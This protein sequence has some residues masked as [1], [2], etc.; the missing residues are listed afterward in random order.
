MKVFVFFV[1]CFTIKQFEVFSENLETMLSFV[2]V[3]NLHNDD[4]FYKKVDISGKENLI[5]YM[6]SITDYREQL[7]DQNLNVFYIYINCKFSNWIIYELYNFVN[8]FPSFY[9]NEF[10]YD[11]IEENVI[12]KD[13]E[14]LK[15][16]LESI[17]IYIEHFITELN[18]FISKK[19][20]FLY[21]SD[22]STLNALL[23]LKLKI[24]FITADLTLSDN[25]IISMIL[26][27]M[28]DIQR[29][30]IIN[31]NDSLPNYE[32]THFYGFSIVKN[33]SETDII[34]FLK[35]IQISGSEF[36]LKREDEICTIN[37]I[38]L[39]TI[40]QSIFD[41]DLQVKVLTTETESIPLIDYFEQ[42]QQSYDIE[43]IF[44]YQKNVLTAI[45]QLLYKLIIMVNM[46]SSS[47]NNIEKKRYNDILDDILKTIADVPM[48]YTN[49]IKK[50]SNLF[51]EAY[52]K[53]DFIENIKIY[54]NSLSSTII[55]DYSRL[56][57]IDVVENKLIKT[58]NALKQNIK[59]IQCFNQYF[60]L[61]HVEHH[62]YYTPFTK[63]TVMIETM[64]E[65]KKS[66]MESFCDFTINIYKLC[67]EITI[68]NNKSAN[69]AQTDNIFYKELLNDFQKIKEY[70]FRLIE[71]IGTKNMELFI[72]ASNI[73]IILVNR[74]MNYLNVFSD[75]KRLAYIIMNELNRY[76]TKYCKPDRYTFLFFNNIYYGE[77][78]NKNFIT[79]NIKQFLTGCDNKESET[80]YNYNHYNLK[81][82]Y[83]N[84]VQNSKVFLYYKNRIKVYWKGEKIDI[85]KFTDIHKFFILNHDFLYAFYDI[86]FKFYV[87]AYFYEIISLRNFITNESYNLEK[88]IT[89]TFK[90]EEFPEGL[91][92]F[93]VKIKYLL[94]KLLLISKCEAENKVK[95]ESKVKNLFQSIELQFNEFGFFLD[96]KLEQNTGYTNDNLTNISQEISSKVKQFHDN[97]YLLVNPKPRFIV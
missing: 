70:L 46:D 62:R 49:Y 47:N 9:H 30:L 4:L 36:N 86:Y 52:D 65:S 96:Y 8:K 25:T 27:I 6:Y 7:S 81:F 67:F 17:L 63:S 45:I 22:K 31:C 95:L 13:Y 48:E 64:K 83:T 74:E 85:E 28:N 55:L 18:T 75:L 3:R 92:S 71:K 12:R 61:L 14:Q 35:L 42:V 88:I 20:S 41:N 2:N 54:D 40:V 82:L 93:I 33:N 56:T 79:R 97:Y 10:L 59:E 23:L 94:E 39:G 19:T 72:T 89:I 53:N 77:F 24:N 66:Y 32:D 43:S 76:G 57:K 16:N 68:L 37:Q 15:A 51:H 73:I 38:L 91:K 29:F 34:H 50:L 44:E 21:Y 84:F 11:L 78:G 5:I 58:F 90:E 80:D 1:L 69:S 60:K 87:A 26:E